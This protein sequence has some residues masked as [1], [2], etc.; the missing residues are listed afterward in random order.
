ME[1]IR[2]YCDADIQGLEPLL[3]PGLRLTG[4]YHSF[5]SAGEYLDALRTD[6]PEAGEYTVLGVTEGEDS[7]A[8]FYDYH[9]PAHG[10]RTAQL[11]KIRDYRIHEIL[12]VFDGRVAEPA[13]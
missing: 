3:A 8:V 4:T 5:S 9:K 6:P 11:F 1:Y 10:M 13:P 7:V 2:R 12:L